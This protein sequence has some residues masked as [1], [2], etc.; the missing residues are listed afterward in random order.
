MEILFAL[1]LV[2]LI[3]ILGKRL[4]YPWNSVKISVDFNPFN[5]WWIPKYYYKKNLT[6]LAKAEGASIVWVRWLIVQISI[7]RWV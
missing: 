4:P 1:A 6:E 2:L 5:I 7:S 3:E